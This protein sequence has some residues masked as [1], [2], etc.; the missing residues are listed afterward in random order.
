MHHPAALAAVPFLVGCAVGVLSVDHTAPGL[1]L[2][3]G[4]ASMLATLAALAWLAEDHPPG[5]AGAVAAAGLLAG[6]SLALTAGREAYRPPLLA[7]YEA[8]PSDVREA[9]IVIEG[10]LREDA[11]LTDY[12]ASLTVDVRRIG[13]AAPPLLLAGGVRLAVGGSSAAASAGAW[14]AGR[15][16][17]MPALLRQ[18]STYRNPGLPDE[19]RAMARRGIIL[20]GTVKSASLVQVIAPGGRTKEA[21]AAARAWTRRTLAEHVGRWSQ[22][23]AAVATAILIGDRSA[24]S[25]DDVR[26]LQ[27]AGTYHVIAIS[28]GNIAILTVL[29]LAAFRCARTPSR[30]SA[31]LTIA[32][33]LF[34]GQLTGAPAS[35]ARAVTAAVVYLAGRMIDHRGPPLN[36]LAVAAIGALAVSPLAVIDAGFILSFGATLGILAGVPALMASDTAWWVGSRA[37]SRLRPSRA[38]RGAS[39]VRAIGNRAFTLLQRAAFTA[40]ALVAATACA[41]LALAPAGASLFSRITFAG[42]ILNFAAIPL[43]TLAQLGAL[44]TLALAPITDLAASGCGRVAHFAAAGLV[45]SARLVDWMPWLSREVAPPAWWL[46]ACYYGGCAALWSA[47]RRRVGAVLIAVTS[48]LMLAAP[49]AVVRDAAPARRGMLRVVFLDVG[50]GDATVVTLPDGRSLLVDAGGLPGTSFDIGARVIAPSLRALGVKR[51]DELIITHGDPDHIGGALTLARQFDPRVIREGAPVPPHAGLRALA[52]HAAAA[53]A[54]WRTVQAGDVDRISGVDLRVLH[55]PLPDWERQRVRN[56]DS[57]V[58]E[59]RFGDVSIV[60]PGDI[61][62]EP[63]RTIAGRLALAPIVILKA[64]HH[65]SLTSS[66]ADFVSATRPAAVVFS[67]GRGNRFGHPAPA[68]LARYRAVPSEIFR[69]DEDGAVLAETDGR[70]VEVRTFSGRRVRFSGRLP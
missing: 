60:L 5:V 30:A 31:A 63:E 26:R 24:L 49:S 22:R 55:P 2:R 27:E 11:S 57:I 53:G 10:I 16:V 8:Q 52:S 9:P 39:L 46:V 35:V 47:R 36:A 54:A 14:R 70:S 18:P 25:D 33:L 68:V 6:T 21:A 34:Y 66:T 38:D 13:E 28:G 1:A 67:A 23:S 20:V 4:A 56:D 43:M 32:G 62:A 58:L 59:L 37:L 41:E 50:Q 40:L 65:G 29:L 7:W 15:T 42:L 48:L 69:T 19:Q 51:L 64:A 17:R 44:A 3:C 45:E 12:G 61:G